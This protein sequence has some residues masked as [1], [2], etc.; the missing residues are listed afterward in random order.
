MSGSTPRARVKI[1]QSDFFS[2]DSLAS[3]TLAKM[4]TESQDS[5]LISKLGRHFNQFTA[6]LNDIMPCQNSSQGI[7]FDM[8]TD[9]FVNSGREMFLSDF[10]RNGIEFSYYVNVLYARRAKAKELGPLWQKMS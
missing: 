5:K 9:R 1:V 7:L 10:E 3:A 8:W 2:K 6:G 4:L